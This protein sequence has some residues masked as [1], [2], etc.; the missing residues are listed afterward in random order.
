MKE[1]KIELC[2]EDLDDLKQL[3]HTDK[4]TEAVTLAIHQALKKQY[5]KKL[6]SLKGKIKW[7]GNLEAMR[8]N[9]VWF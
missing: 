6:L 3:Y 8:E 9:R 4:E 2:E 7:I 1:L 5:Y